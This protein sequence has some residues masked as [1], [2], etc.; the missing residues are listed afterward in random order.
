MNV[1]AAWKHMPPDWP[2]KDTADGEC[3]QETNMNFDPKWLEGA[4]QFQQQ[5]FGALGSLGSFGWP[6]ASAA[7]DM[8]KLMPDM[9]ALKD[10]L[11]GAGAHPV[12]LEPGRLMDIQRQY[13]QDVA[14]L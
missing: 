11:S 8:S 6:G 2:V 3:R 4:Q 13:L 1:S 10:V 5:M 14:Q 7:P 12:K 9:G